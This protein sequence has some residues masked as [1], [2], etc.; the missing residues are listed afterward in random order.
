MSDGTAEIPVEVLVGFAEGVR[1][2]FVSCLQFFIFDT[3]NPPFA[4][5]QYFQGKPLFQWEQMACDG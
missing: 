3:S 1:H 5:F 2:N 4:P